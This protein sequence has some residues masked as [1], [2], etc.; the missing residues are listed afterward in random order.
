MRN[1]RLNR[2]ITPCE[3]QRVLNHLEAL[4]LPGYRQA[5]S[6]ADAGYTPDFD[7]T[8]LSGF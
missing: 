8:G 2:R 5:L 3:Y 4:E 7:L 1:A 6:A